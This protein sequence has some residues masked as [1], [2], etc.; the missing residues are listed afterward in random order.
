[1]NLPQARRATPVTA[2]PIYVTVPATFARD[3]IVQIGNE[4]IRI[5]ILPERVR[6]ALLERT[7]KSLF[8]RGDGS[9]AYK[10]IVYV[11]DKLKAA[12]VEK[13]GLITVPVGTR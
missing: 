1:V 10:D 2:Q 13:V 5:D 8:V 7:E 3:H 6:Q 12:G 4:E 9:V 11:F